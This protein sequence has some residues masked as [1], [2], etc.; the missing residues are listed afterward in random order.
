MRFRVG[1]PDLPEPGNRNTSTPVEE[2]EGA[3]NCRCG[4]TDESRTHK[5]GECELYKEE[6]NVL[7]QEMRETSECNMENSSISV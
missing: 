2:K 4:D 6:R 7:E 1:E 3:Q 5:V